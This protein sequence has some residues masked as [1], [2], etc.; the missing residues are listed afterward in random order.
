MMDDIRNGNNIPNQFPTNGQDWANYIGHLWNAN[1]QIQLILEFEDRLNIPRMRKAVRLSIDAEPILGCTFVE[2]EQLPFWERL[3]HLDARNCFR[4][5]EVQDRDEAL[6]I[7]LTQPFDSEEQQLQV[8]LIR[9]NNAD[10]LCIKLNHA[11]CDGG[12]AKEY[13]QLLLKIYNHLGEDETYRPESN[14]AG[15]RDAARLFQTLGIKDPLLAFNPQLAALKPTWSF[16]YKEVEAKSFHFST[17][18]LDKSQT[19]T[20]HS[21]AKV[22]GATLNDL[23]LTAFYRALFVIVQPEEAEPM[24]ICVTYDL[25]N[26]LPDKKADAI[27]NLSS[28]VNHRIAKREGESPLAT[29]KRVSLVMNE[30]K[31]NKPGIHSA[32]TLEMLMGIGF[33]HAVASI[34]AA[35]EEAVK[36]RMSTINLSNMGIVAK[37]PLNFGGLIAKQAYLV[38]PVFRSPS[39][40]LGVSSYDQRLTFTVG[41]CEPEMARSDVDAFFSI[42]QKEL[43]SFQG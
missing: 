28:V 43:L 13:L 20:L 7:T 10:T 34:K 22:N 12:G 41:Y 19:G 33:K 8:K 24:E 31:N 25:R 27:C 14:V 15:Q 23:I 40:M 30:I 21:Y 9:S 17:L 5:E 42:L 18:R 32:A 4:W 16:P 2:N 29:L 11:C 37:Y 1:R 38:T 6:T 39:F 35:W 3:E 36:S 26:Y